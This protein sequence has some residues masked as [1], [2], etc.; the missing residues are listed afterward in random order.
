MLSQLPWTVTEKTA[1]SQAVPLPLGSGDGYSAV[2]A[3]CS[4][5]FDAQSIVTCI[6]CIT[7]FRA[8]LDIS[9]LCKVQHDSS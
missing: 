7:C 3:S 1:V 8:P 5:H 9:L 6:S 4:A 2:V